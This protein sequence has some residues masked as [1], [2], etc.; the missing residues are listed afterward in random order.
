MVSKII[1]CEGCGGYYVRKS[2]L[3]P[4]LGFF[5]RRRENDVS[6]IKL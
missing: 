3:Y 4:P 6:A 5:D 2:G 1:A